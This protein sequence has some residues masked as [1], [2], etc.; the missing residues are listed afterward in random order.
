MAPKF[1]SHTNGTQTVDGASGKNNKMERGSSVVDNPIW[2]PG[3]PQSPKQRTDG[4][5]T[6]SNGGAKGASVKSRTTPENQ[7]GKTGQVEHVHAQPS[8]RGKNAG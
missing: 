7:H 6:G 2:T 8:L 5:L 1:V 3:G 4:P